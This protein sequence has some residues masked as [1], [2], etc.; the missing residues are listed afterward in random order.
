MLPKKGWLFLGAVAIAI[1][2]WTSLSLPG[3]SRGRNR[4]IKIKAK[5]FEDTP[6]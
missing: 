1:L 6:N 5:I 3:N 4:R 2:A